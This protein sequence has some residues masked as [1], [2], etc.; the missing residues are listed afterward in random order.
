M[1][2]SRASCVANTLFKS[3]KDGMEEVVRKMGNA[4]LKMH[5]ARDRV[6]GLLLA[7]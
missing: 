7:R 6:M 4:D 3:F 5:T 2:T 1:P